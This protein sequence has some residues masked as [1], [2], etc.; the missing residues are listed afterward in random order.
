MATGITPSILVRL[1]RD[2]VVSDRALTDDHGEYK[3]V[4]LRTGAYAVT[5]TLTCFSTI[6][7]EGIELTAGFTATVNADLPVGALAE[8]VTVSG[9]SPI[10]DTHN[11]RSQ[12]L[13]NANSVLDG[14]TTRS[15]HSF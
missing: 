12:N 13:L 6:K 1:T 15:G 4:E 5:S 11:V 14:E 10:V 3:I 7:H 9:G 8:T 2:Q